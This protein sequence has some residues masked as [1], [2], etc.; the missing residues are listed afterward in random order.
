MFSGDTWHKRH[1]HEFGQPENRGHGRGS[2]MRGNEHARHHDDET[3]SDWRQRGSNGHRGR[4]RRGEARFLLLDVLKDGPLHGYEIIRL[5]HERSSGAYTPSPG[6]VYPTLQHFEDIGLVTVNQEESRKVYQLT[7]EG[8]AEV[9]NHA[10]EIALF[11][12]QFVQPELSG[13]CGAETAFLKHETQDLMRA[14][15]F[16]VDQLTVRDNA[17]GVRALRQAVE[18][19]KAE[20][21]TII[22]QVQCVPVVNSDSENH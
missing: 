10:E 13:A 14:L 2:G 8:R 12:K 15:W 5:L 11:W 7:D 1:H 6:T 19:C 22:T 18:R 16:G 9:A 17:E 4:A 21:R 20:V 3:E